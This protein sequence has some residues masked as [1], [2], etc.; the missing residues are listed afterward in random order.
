LRGNLPFLR[1]IHYITI[2]AAIG[3]TALIYWGGNTVPPKKNQPVNAGQQPAGMMSQQ[4]MVMPASFDSI[5][6]ASRKRLSVQAGADIEILD[7]KLSS[8][9][10]SVAM[11][12]IFT[13]LAKKMAGAQNTAG[14][15][16][17]LC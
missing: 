2:A 3:L 7:R 12:P 9:S 1:P 13:E 4:A 16:L 6:S 10:D 17:L 11:A 5:L 14:C 8:I 15:S